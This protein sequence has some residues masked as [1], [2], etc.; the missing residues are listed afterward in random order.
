MLIL[1]DTQ[2]V[3]LAIAPVDARG[4]PAKVDG[5]PVWSVAGAN[6]DILELPAAA[7]GLSCVVLTKGPLGT[8]QVVVAA[9]ADLGAGTKAIQGVLDIEVQASEA[10]AL[11]VNAAVPEEL[12][13]TPAPV[14]EPEPEPAPEPAPE[15]EPL[16]VEPPVDPPVE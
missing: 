9:D 2:K 7:D 14:P 3:S 8:A 10:V 16:P 12:D 6:P 1:K 13:L 15:P 5:A 4:N 11:G